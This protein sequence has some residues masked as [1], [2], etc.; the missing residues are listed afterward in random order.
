MVEHGGIGGRH[1]GEQ[2]AALALD[3]L[4]H[5]HGIEGGNADIGGAVLQRAQDIQ[6][7]A[8]A[9]EQ[10]DDGGPAIAGHDAEAFAGAPGIGEHGAMG[11][12]GAL[13]ESGGARGIEQ[14]RDIAGAHRG[15]GALGHPAPLQQRVIAHRGARAAVEADDMGEL[16]QFRAQRLDHLEIGIRAEGSRQ[17]QRLAVGLGEGESEIVMPVMAVERHHHHAGQRDGELGD[18]PFQTVLRQ[19]RHMGAGCQ[20]ESEKPARQ[21]LGFRQPGPEAP[22]S[23]AQGEGQGFRRRAQGRLMAQRR[24]RCL[25]RGESRRAHGASRSSSRAM[26]LRWTSEAPS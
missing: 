23:A 24:A 8:R 10:R 9:V 22:P 17:Q 25:E 21:A 20:A 7:A 12:Q 16:R 26:M 14:G 15:Q 11:E 2:G 1:A 19:Q 13:G 5:G 3:D 18:R 4:E 6:D